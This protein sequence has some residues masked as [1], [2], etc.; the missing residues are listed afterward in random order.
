MV[1]T[2]WPIVKLEDKKKRSFL[3]F[4]F[5]TALFVYFLFPLK[6]FA[7]PACNDLVTFGK[8]AIQNMRFGKGIAFSMIIMFG[9]PVLIMGG[10]AAVM[11]RAEKRRAQIFKSE[12]QP[13]S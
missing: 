10:L 1:E 9:M 13:R 11:I 4:C 2:G 3:Y 6:A 5:W 12:N 7:C 8:D